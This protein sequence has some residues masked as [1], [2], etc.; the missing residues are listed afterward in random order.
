MLSLSQKLRATRQ[1]QKDEANDDNNDAS[2]RSAT[3]RIDS[4]VMVP[5][6]SSSLPETNAD[7]PPGR[8]RY[9]AT[10]INISAEDYETLQKEKMEKSSWSHSLLQNVFRA[11]TTTETSSSSSTSVTAVVGSETELRRAV[12]TIE[13]DVQR[14]VCWRAWMALDQRQKS[15]RHVYERC[16]DTR[17]QN[18][19]ISEKDAAQIEIDVSRALPDVTRFDT[20]HMESLRRVLRAYACYN[21]HIG[22]G[23]GMAFLTAVFLLVLQKNEEQTFHALSYLLDEILVDYFDASTSGA[24]IDLKILSYYLKVSEKKVYDE[25]KDMLSAVAV[26]WLLGMFVHRLPL[27][28]VLLIWDAVLCRGVSALLEYAV[29]FFVTFSDDYCRKDVEMCDRICT[30]NQRMAGMYN[31]DII[32]QVRVHPPFDE[33]IVRLRRFT[34]APCM[35]Q[36]KKSS[37]KSKTPATTPR[38]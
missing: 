21:P 13:D 11:V 4:F 8:D 37:T 32:Q 25:C 1:Q 27:E 14:A 20:E 3:P 6:S 23:Q 30:I 34:F 19:T 18:E 33:S 28:S 17:I 22:Y 5:Q 29:R 26:Q 12:T 10:L 38:K 15:R 36:K 35:S 31:L 16:C 2:S 9:G 7:K 24:R